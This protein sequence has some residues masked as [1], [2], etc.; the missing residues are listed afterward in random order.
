M[1]KF[2]KE[3]IIAMA[4][5]RRAALK[6]V[7]T[8]ALIREQLKSFLPETK[9]GVISQAAA[10]AL[11]GILQGGIPWEVIAGFLLAN[12][13]DKGDIAAY[14]ELISRVLPKKEEASVPSTFCKNGRKTVISVDIPA[15]RIPAPE[16]V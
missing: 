10:C 9:R 16:E 15:M 5:E 3:Q 6:Q 12:A 7:P 2:T 8:V 1:S 14:K 11:S 13:V 4:N